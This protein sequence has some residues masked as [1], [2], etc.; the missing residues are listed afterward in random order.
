MYQCQ[1]KLSVGYSNNLDGFSADEAA[2][3]T[4]SLM[5][6]VKQTYGGF[7]YLY[8]VSYGTYVSHRIIQINPDAVDAVILDGV[9][10]GKFCDFTKV[11]TLSYN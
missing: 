8:G 4:L 9:C 11:R 1:N 3:D 2:M 5:K 6:A 10:G 7:N